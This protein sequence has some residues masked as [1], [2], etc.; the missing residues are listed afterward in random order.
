MLLIMIL[1]HHLLLEIRLYNCNV[2]CSNEY[3]FYSNDK[4]CKLFHF[5][6]TERF[7]DCLNQ[8]TFYYSQ[9]RAQRLWGGGGDPPT[10][11]IKEI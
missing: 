5:Q 10:W 1:L 4:C 9:R 8:Q 11:Q 7:V 2:L 3:N 6:K